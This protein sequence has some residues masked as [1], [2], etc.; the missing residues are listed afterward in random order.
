MSCSQA[1]M[2]MSRMIKYGKAPLQHLIHGHRLSTATEMIKNE[3]CMVHPFAS[4]IP[5]FTG[6]GLLPAFGFGV[7]NI[8]ISQYPCSVNPISP[9]SLGAAAVPAVDQS[10]V[11][12]RGRRIDKGAERDVDL[13]DYDSSAGSSDTDFDD[14]DYDDEPDF[15]DDDD[16][17]ERDDNEDDQRAQKTITSTGSSLPIDK[18]W[19][20]R[21]FKLY[22]GFWYSANTLEGVVQVQQQF[23]AQPSDVLLCTIPKAGTTWLKA[24]CFAIMN[25]ACGFR[26][27]SH[28]LLT[29][30]PHECVPFLEL[31]ADYKNPAI[32]LI[33]THIPYTSLPESVFTSGCKIVYMIRNPKDMFV[34][35]WHFMEKMTPKGMVSPSLEVAFELFSNGIS[36]YGPYWDHVLGY[37]KA[38]LESPE[39]ILF[40]KFEDMKR[41]P[42]IWVRK[43]VQFL[44]HP[45]SYDAERNGEV[46]EIVE[47]CS[48]ENL[49]NLEV[50]KNGRHQTGAQLL[51]ENNVYFRQ[52]VVGDWKN[53]LTTEMAEHLGP[54]HRAEV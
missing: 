18:A 25:R 12:V 28:P 4:E 29:T 54:N 26:Y 1:T 27:S 5:P 44:D 17:D 21:H 23:K 47:L 52:G 3:S 39:K 30:S 38:S 9:R 50:N 31:C 49:S 37:W 35:L 13:E 15:D 22:Q 33:A 20:A 51:M 34:S 32:P 42:V 8:R 19:I 45:F 40:L 43:L 10:R 41:E 6:N 2:A 14:K 7:D 53:H 36:P 16:D 48:F 24:L 46:Q 11:E